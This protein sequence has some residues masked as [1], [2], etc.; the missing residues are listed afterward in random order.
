KLAIRI[1]IVGVVITCGVVPIGYIITDQ[2]APEKAEAFRE[3]IRLEKPVSE[4]E[5]INEKTKIEEVLNQVINVDESEELKEKQLEELKKFKE[6]AVK[7]VKT[8]NVP[9]ISEEKI[10]EVA[11]MVAKHLT[12]EIKILKDTITNLERKLESPND[13]AE[14]NIPKS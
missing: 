14:K 12:S 4:E 5:I 7:E 9:F 2:V 13:K 3:F 8:T 10:K 1:A 6:K 11:V